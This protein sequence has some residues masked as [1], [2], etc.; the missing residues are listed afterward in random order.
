M[1]GQMYSRMM[2][3]ASAMLLWWWLC[4]VRGVCSVN[5]QTINSFGYFFCE[6]EIR[7]HSCSRADDGWPRDRD[8]VIPL[9]VCHVPS[10]P[11]GSA[12]NEPVGTAAYVGKCF[13][14]MVFSIFTVP[15]SAAR[16]V[17]N[18]ECDEIVRSRRKVR[19]YVSENF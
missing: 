9:F 5:S 2:V 15:R 18:E 19:H 13:N 17:R 12:R 6:R 4:G 8:L 16:E 3:R 10:Q 14:L 11:Y 7:L 1:P